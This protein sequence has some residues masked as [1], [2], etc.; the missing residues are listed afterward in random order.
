M[1][2]IQLKWEKMFAFARKFANAMKGMTLF[3][4]FSFLNIIMITIRQ[5]ENFE[6]R[7]W[8]LL[9]ALTNCDVDYA[10]CTKKN[11]TNWT[12]EGERRKKSVIQ[13]NC[14]LIIEPVNRYSIQNP[15]TLIAHKIVLPQIHARFYSQ[16]LLMVVRVIRW[17]WQCM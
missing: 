5:S 1:F 13:W 16:K 11:P 4:V 17:W 12:S 9:S 3:V 7:N 15:M 6:V 10:T 2:Q 14:C 8:K